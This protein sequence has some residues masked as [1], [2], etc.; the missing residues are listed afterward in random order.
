MINLTA[1]CYI[2]VANAFVKIF[3]FYN[4]GCLGPSQRLLQGDLHRTQ[5]KEWQTK[6]LHL[7]CIFYLSRRRGLITHSFKKQWVTFL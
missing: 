6:S 3:K 1:C 7:I 4:S 2:L 5:M